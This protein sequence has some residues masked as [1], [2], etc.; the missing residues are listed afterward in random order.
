MS[1]VNAVYNIVSIAV[2]KATESGN[3]FLYP[4]VSDLSIAR[5]LFIADFSRFLISFGISLQ[6]YDYE[7]MADYNSFFI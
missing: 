2:R 1:Y 4:S 5:D 6:K 7:Y 3:N